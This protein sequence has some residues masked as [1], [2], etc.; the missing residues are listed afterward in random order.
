MRGGPYNTV[1]QAAAASGSPDTVKTILAAR[2]GA[3]VNAQGGELSTSFASTTQ[4]RIA[5]GQSRQASQPQLQKK[6]KT[7]L[8]HCARKVC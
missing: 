4:S 8:Q 3:D 2:G 6:G 1:L 5:S 7:M